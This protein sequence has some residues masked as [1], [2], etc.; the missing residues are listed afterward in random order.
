MYTLDIAT[1]IEDAAI[2][3]PTS[4]DTVGVMAAAEPGKTRATT[5]WRAPQATPLPIPPNR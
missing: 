2:L 5:F 1:V 4:V 3:P